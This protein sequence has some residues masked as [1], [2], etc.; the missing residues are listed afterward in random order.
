MYPREETV[1]RLEREVG[2]GLARCD[3]EA[4]GRYFADDFIGIN[5]MSVE[6]T[7]AEVLAQ[8]GSSDYEPE[9][10]VNDVRSVRVFGNVAVVVAHGTAK[11][12]YKG[13]RADMMFAY[14]RI[15]VDRGGLWQAVVSLPM[16]VRY[17]R[18]V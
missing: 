4:L 7:K 8:I 14:T 1:A 3:V 9:S 13:Q 11:G 5:P 16:R 18:A 6:M 10:I 2:E 12:R 17:R 15:W